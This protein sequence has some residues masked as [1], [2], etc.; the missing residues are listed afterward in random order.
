MAGP[1]LTASGLTI[2]TAAEILAE[3][4]GQLRANASQPGLLAEPG[5]PLGVIGQTIADRERSLQEA[6]QA[7]YTSFGLDASGVSLDRVAQAFGLTRNTATR[8]TVVVPV[9][10]TSGG[11]I[12]ITLGSQLRNTSTSD[13]F[14]TTAALTLGA[15][16][17]DN[18]SVQA[19]VAGAIPVPSGITWGWIT[20]GY[21]A[22][23]FGANAAGA[24][25]V[26]A[27][28]DA[29]LRARWLVS[30]AVAGAGTMD[31]ILTSMLAL[32][33]ITDAR[34]Y[35][36]TTL[37]VGITTPEPIS[38][39]PA[40]SIVVVCY[41]TATSSDIA[42]A[43]WGVKPA[44]IETWGSSTGTATDSQGVAHSVDYEAAS[45][46]TCN[47][48]LTVT[49]S[50]AD[51]DTAIT[52]AVTAL[53]TA[54]TLG[55]DVI[56]QRIECAALDASGPD[57]TLVLSNTNTAGDGV[58]VAIDWNRYAALNSVTINHV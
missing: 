9:T 23:T 15:G 40:K 38:L 39:L 51:Y 53:F 54:L 18:L 4:L 26:A 32:P 47:V 21:S 3:W 29:E 25:G 31:A 44:G 6:L 49:G 41:G 24:Q 57:T 16:A 56:A 7:L 52:A 35:E 34:V 58:D 43:I 37:S 17:T 1:V 48:V 50:S 55:D 42:Q 14:E 45:A 20:S 19:N 36:N 2:Q 13:Q 30:Y 33:G 28:T 22:V 8:S 5:T 10:N 27:E 46:T 12:T 11:P